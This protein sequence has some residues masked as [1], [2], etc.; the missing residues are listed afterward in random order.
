[1]CLQDYDS[2]P[3]CGLVES[4]S[5]ADRAATAAPWESTWTWAPPAELRI[6]AA[7]RGAVE[8]DPEDEPEDPEEEDG[9]DFDEDDDL[10]DDM[11][12]DEPGEYDDDVDDDLIDLDDEWDDR[13]EEDR[14]DSPH[15]Y[16]E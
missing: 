16:Y 9:D 12:G 15:R 3:P 5:D 7:R 13:D 8:P 11:D 6:H 14:R 10:N 1:M 2:L 4:P